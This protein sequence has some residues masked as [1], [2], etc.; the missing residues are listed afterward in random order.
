MSQY[1]Q[2]CVYFCRNSFWLIYWWL[3]DYPSPFLFYGIFLNNILWPFFSQDDSFR[4]CVCTSSVIA[5]KPNNQINY[6][7]FHW[8]CINKVFP[9]PL[10]IFSIKN[11]SSCPL[12][13]VNKKRLGLV[14]KKKKTYVLWAN[15]VAKVSCAINGKVISFPQN[16]TFHWPH[17]TDR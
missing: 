17:P 6:H 14:R 9:G 15:I 1:L 8:W 16:T 7:C 3:F 10:K 5:I 12:I 4:V 2:L 11:C 13:S